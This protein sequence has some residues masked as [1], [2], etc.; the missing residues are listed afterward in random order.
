[1]V[2]QL[3]LFSKLFLDLRRTAA[4]GNRSFVFKTHVI[5]TLQLQGSG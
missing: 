5:A 1:M 4:H 3:R 2:I